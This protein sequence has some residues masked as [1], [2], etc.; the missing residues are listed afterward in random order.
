[1]FKKVSHYWAMLIGVLKAFFV[2]HTQNNLWIQ[3]SDDSNE[4]FVRSVEVQYAFFQNVKEFA[5]YWRLSDKATN[6][7]MFKFALPFLFSVSFN[8]ASKHW[9]SVFTFTG[10]F[11]AV[12]YGILLDR[13]GLNLY[14]RWGE[15]DILYETGG[16]RLNITPRKLHVFFFGEFV[17]AGCNQKE[18]PP[19]F[20][21]VD[22]EGGSVLLKISSRLLETKYIADGSITPLLYDYTYVSDVKVISPID[23]SLPEKLCK[24]VLRV[25]NSNCYE[26]VVDSIVDDINSY[27]AS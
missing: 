12:T 22:C 1:M 9:R 7:F 11:V 10:K 16:K 6:C 27:L 4:F 17:H 23:I 8:V 19:A 15:C 2:V 13:N 3:L 18:M 26:S 21:F 5:F 20:R 25:K 14:W 24:Q